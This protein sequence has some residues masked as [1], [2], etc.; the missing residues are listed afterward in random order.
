VTT[1]E[2]MCLWCDKELR[3]YIVDEAKHRSRRPELQE[4][5]IQEAWLSISCAYFGYDC[6]SYKKLAR[7]AIYGSY[8]QN[9]KEYLLMQSN[10]RHYVNAKF[11]TAE[12]PTDNDKWFMQEKGWRD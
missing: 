5:Y 1:E 10:N 4:E 9:R 2:F 12:A 11:K 3:Q 6:E 8:W 7:L